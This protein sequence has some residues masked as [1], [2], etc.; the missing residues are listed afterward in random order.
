MYKTNRSQGF[1]LI[2]VM[3]V[4]ALIAILASIAYPSYTS[5]VNRSNRG[6]AISILLEVAGKQEKAYGQSFTYA[7]SM[8]TLGYGNSNDYTTPGGRYT[9]RVRAA[10]ATSFTLE[11]EP[12]NSQLKDVCGTLTYTNAG[13]KAVENKGDVD[14][15]W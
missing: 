15:C 9:V 10:D 2:E 12:I 13:F 11:A 3:I 6:E 4:V 7:N 8:A 14:S 5:S 1:T